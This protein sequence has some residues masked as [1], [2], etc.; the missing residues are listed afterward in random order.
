MPFGLTNAPADFQAFINDVLRP[1][2]NYFCSA[3][4]ND[5]LVYS[6]SLDEYKTYV[7]RVLDLLLANGLHLNLEKCEFYR[8]KV[9]YLGIIISEKGI[10]MDPAKVAAIIT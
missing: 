6:N 2:L 4:L 5:I 8:T 9:N 1:H 3:Y 7:R 10:S